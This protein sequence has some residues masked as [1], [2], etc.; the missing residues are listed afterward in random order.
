LDNLSVTTRS[1]PATPLSGVNGTT[2][3]LLK[4]PGTPHAPDTQ[5]FGTRVNSQGPVQ[6]HENPVNAGDLQA[7]LSRLPSGQY[8]NGSLPFNSV[9]AGNDDSLQVSVSGLNQYFITDP[10]CINN[11]MATLST[12]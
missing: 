7:S 5:G 8:E 9:Q 12:T 11:S 3:H 4:T 10:V 2:T 6:A 1:V